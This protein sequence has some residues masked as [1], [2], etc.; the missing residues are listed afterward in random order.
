MNQTLHQFSSRVSEVSEV[1]E[2]PGSTRRRLQAGLRGAATNAQCGENLSGM[3]HLHAGA[4]SKRLDNKSIGWPLDKL[5]EHPTGFER[6][7]LERADRDSQMPRKPRAL[8]VVFTCGLQSSQKPGVQI[9]KPPIRTIK[10][11]L[12]GLRQPK[13]RKSAN[14]VA[15][16]EHDSTKCLSNHLRP[17]GSAD[18]QGLQ[19]GARAAPSL[20]ASLSSSS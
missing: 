15:N 14:I 1:A 9:A 6:Q 5:W 12:K 4:R 20:W 13:S 17:K 7:D 19:A 18:S 16:K 11:I 3:S 2:P 8:Q 10:G